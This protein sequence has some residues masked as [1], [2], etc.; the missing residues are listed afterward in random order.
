MREKTE[1]EGRSAKKLDTALYASWYQLGEPILDSDGKRKPFTGKANQIAA[2]AAAYAAAG[3]NHLIIG[4]ESDD[5]R[6]WLDRIEKFATE[7]MPLA[8]QQ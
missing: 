2:D 6:V 8:G 5:L 4:F 7:V 1:I 3:L